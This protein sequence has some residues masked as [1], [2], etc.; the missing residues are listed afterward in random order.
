MTIAQRCDCAGVLYGDGD[1]DLFC[2]TISP[3]VE[4]RVA[5]SQGG[6]TYY[7]QPFGDSPWCTCADYHYR[8][9]ICKHIRKLRGDDMTTPQTAVALRDQYMPEVLDGVTEAVMNG[10]LKGLSPVV[11]IEYYNAVCHAVGINPMARPFEYIP[12]TGGK[13][14]LYWT[15][16][17]AFT[18]GAMHGGSVED[19]GGHFE[20]DAFVVRAI[21]RAPGGRMATNIGR[22][23][24]GPTTRWDSG[25]RERVPVPALSGQD[26]E[27]AKMK[28]VTKAQRRAFLTLCGVSPAPGIT[29]DMV[30][31]EIIVQPGAINMPALAPQGSGNAQALRAAQFRTGSP[32]RAGQRACVH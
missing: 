5:A 32:Y 18:L 30:S 17:G 21:A 25:K 14:K 10:D 3:T 29:T 24:V 2:T 13:E 28:A 6:G 16:V 12:V 27:D 15:A 22:L 26:L 11:K 23:Y 31:G 8:H 19:D 1:H 20:G 4:Y 9:R 7:V